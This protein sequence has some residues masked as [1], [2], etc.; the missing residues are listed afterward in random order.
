MRYISRIILL[1]LVLFLACEG[2]AGISQWVIL[3]TALG[4]YVVIMYGR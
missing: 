4:A 1:I 2:L 3:A